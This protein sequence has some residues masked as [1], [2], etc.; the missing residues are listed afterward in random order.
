MYSHGMQLVD[1]QDIMARTTCLAS[2]PESSVKQKV[3]YVRR[4]YLQ[5]HQREEVA[6]EDEQGGAEA[7]EQACDGFNQ[8]V[9]A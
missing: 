9:N 8:S 2:K 6:E 5:R 7:V 3:I 4:D 1:G